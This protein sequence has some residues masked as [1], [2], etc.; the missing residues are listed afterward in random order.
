MDMKETVGLLWGII[1]VFSLFGLFACFSSEDASNQEKWEVPERKL[2]FSPISASD[3]N[4]NPR[5]TTSI[6]VVKIF[7]FLDLNEKS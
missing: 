4:F 3:S 1:L 6:P 5:N 2:S 7:V